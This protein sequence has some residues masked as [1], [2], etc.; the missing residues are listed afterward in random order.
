MILFVY[1]RAFFCLH[2]ILRVSQPNRRFQK[3]KLRKVQE[4]VKES[5]GHK[6]AE[7]RLGWSGIGGWKLIESDSVCLEGRNF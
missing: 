2:V 5:S 7:I 4:F 3:L 6:A 1:M